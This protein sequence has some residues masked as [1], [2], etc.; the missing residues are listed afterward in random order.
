MGWNF[1]DGIFAGRGAHVFDTFVK[2]NDDGIKP[3]QGPALFERNVLWGMENGWPLMLAW[4]T[5]SNES[6]QTQPNSLSF[7]NHRRSYSHLTASPIQEPGFSLDFLI[8]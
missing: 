1:A 3:F 7:V 8:P 5:E 2:V 4:N 6:N